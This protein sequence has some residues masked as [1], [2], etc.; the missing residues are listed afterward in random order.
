MLKVEHLMCYKVSMAKDN[1]FDVVSTVELQ[2]VDNAVDQ[3]RREIA[4]RFDFKGVQAEIARDKE[5]LVLSAQDKNR[6]AAL[7]EILKQ[8]LIRRNVHVQNLTFD[9]VQETPGGFARQD[10]QIGMGIPDQTAKDISKFIR[11]LK[12]KVQAQIQGNLVRVNSKSRDDLQAVMAELKS[13][14]FGRALQFVN[15]R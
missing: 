3:A 11:D 6:L 15:Y 10:V 2:E 7:L 12:M 8:K 1:S 14:D 5:K 13:K 9:E 4:N